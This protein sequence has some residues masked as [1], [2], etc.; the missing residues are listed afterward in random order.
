[1]TIKTRI[2]GGFLAIVAIF[3]LILIT[4]ILQEGMNTGFVTILAVAGIAAAVVL[5]RML[6]QQVV[7]PI[8]RLE[9]AVRASGEEQNPEP[10]RSLSID[11]P[12]E[13][14]TLLAQFQELVEKMAQVE[15][16]NANQDSKKRLA[17]SKALTTVTRQM[18]DGVSS[19]T[20]QTDKLSVSAEKLNVDLN[21]TT[22][23][24]SDTAAQLQTVAT[25]SMEMDANMG[26]IS[27][28]AEEASTNL[29]VVVMAAE[30][31]N[32]NMMAIK[33]ATDRAQEGI[34]GVAAAVEQMT[35]SLENIRQRCEST[36]GESKEAIQQTKDAA[37]VVEK[38]AV[39]SQEIGKAVAIIK[40]IAGQTNMLALNASIEAAGAGEAGK[41]FAVVANEVK[42]LAR[43]T[44]EATKMISHSIGEIQ[45]GTEEAISSVAG[46]V[47]K[48]EQ[49][50]Q[51][52]EE[53]NF[54]VSEQ[55]TTLLDVVRSM[56][57]AVS[58][59]VEVTKKV[60]D[61]T[62]SLMDLVR[63]MSEI[64]IGISEVTRNVAE[65][66]T[67]IKEM[68]SKAGEA[69]GNGGDLLGAVRGA[70]ETSQLL[71]SMTGDL[72]RSVQEAGEL[73]QTVNDRVQDLEQSAPAGPP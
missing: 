24:I 50:G 67:G 7:L 58:E 40:Q 4:R 68:A 21:A 5:A 59:T 65:A 62:A 35:A 11:S 23:T 14:Q 28:A 63:G 57:G 42:D 49:I 12:G 16:S 26:A 60:D 43:Q 66:S 29:N 36:A 46:I 38:L 20:E 72:A 56:G 64:A 9:E 18:A 48:I 34:G 71:V 55:N 2:I 32:T 1:M 15:A 30:T 69:A 37:R 22:T 3:A 51:A 27:A 33:E 17:A 53:I 52:N 61:S 39:T 31:S 8:A 44:A 47:N 10:I 25:S 41:G 54:A 19:L 6:V 45:D 70:V 73:R 13:L